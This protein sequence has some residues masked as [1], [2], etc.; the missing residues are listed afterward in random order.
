MPLT[1]TQR[2]VYR[3]VGGEDQK[4]I[5]VLGD[6]SYPTG[7]YAVT[8]ALFNFNAFATDGYGTGLPP[9]IGYYW[10]VSGFDTATTADVVAQQNPVN[11]NLQFFLTS[12]GAELGSGTSAVTYGAI[13]VAYGH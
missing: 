11:G 6:A 5:S 13:L 1:A 7:G 10:I 8:P 3:G 12:T 4:S 2:A 9:V